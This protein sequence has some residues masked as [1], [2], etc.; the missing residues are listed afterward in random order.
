MTTSITTQEYWNWQF[1]LCPITGQFLL[2]NQE[3]SITDL[4]GQDDH[5]NHYTII[6][7]LPIFT[8]PDHWTIHT[9]SSGKFDHWS[10][11]SYFQ[12]S[13]L[14]L[15]NN[16]ETG[17]IPLTDH[18]TIY[19][20]WSGKFAQRVDGHSTKLEKYMKTI[21]MALLYIL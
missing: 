9:T 12:S 2:G 20:R 17:N 19:T 6:L 16:I 18:W 3:N 10:V 7:K 8:F 4:G 21:I 1:F 11:W 15:Q 5:F 13:P 14:S